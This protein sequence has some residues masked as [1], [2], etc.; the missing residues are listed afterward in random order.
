MRPSM[1]APS[2]TPMASAKT[3][4]NG[5]KIDV[6]ALRMSVILGALNWGVGHLLHQLPTTKQW[7]RAWSR[8][9]ESNHQGTT[10]NRTRTPL[11]PAYH[12]NSATKRATMY[13][14]TAS[15]AG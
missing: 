12:A 14:T 6:A 7:P 1:R 8:M 2:V 9:V 10:T 3:L 13:V 5:L 15:A 11:H 4:T